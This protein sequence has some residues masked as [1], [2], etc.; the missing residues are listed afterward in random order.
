MIVFPEPLKYNYTYDQYWD[1]IKLLKAKFEK[2]KSPNIVGIYRGSLSI[3]AHLSN[4][5]NCGMSIVKFQSRDGEDK[6]ASFILDSSTSDSDIVVVDDIY[7]SG[8]TIQAV[9]S[10]YFSHPHNSIQYFTL[11]GKPNS[12]GVEFFHFN[13]DQWIVFPW[14]RV[15][16]EIQK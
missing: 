12:V 6:S 16:N 4:L 9:Q 2:L 13:N 5:L 10:L 3:A 15:E 11:Y 1:D 14:E 8:K 7:D